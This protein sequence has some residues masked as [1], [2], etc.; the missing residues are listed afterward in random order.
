ME[1]MWQAKSWCPQQYRKTAGGLNTQP[2]QRN[3]MAQHQATVGPQTS[4]FLQE[5]GAEIEKLILNPRKWKSWGTP[6]PAGLE[7]WRNL[8]LENPPVSV[9]GVGE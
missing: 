3:D 2:F 6:F 1:G 9:C 4:A 8:I 5:R 7:S